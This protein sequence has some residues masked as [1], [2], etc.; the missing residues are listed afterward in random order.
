M[1][2]LH[3]PRRWRIAGILLLLAVLAAAMAPA[4]LP[5]SGRGSHWSLLSDKWLHGITFTI[6]AVWFSGQYARRSYW[7]LGIGL[8]I[9]GA[10]IELCQ[11]FVIY[12]TAESADL[13]ADTLGIAVGFGLAL[14]GIGGWSLRLENWL[15][16]SRARS[17]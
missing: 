4:I 7:L 9:F 11:S 1:L 6:L 2:P 8:L 10:L 12:R 16:K 15:Q 3:H 14:L 13:M 17:F 5:W